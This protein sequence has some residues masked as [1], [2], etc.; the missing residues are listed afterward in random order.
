[1]NVKRLIN[2]C[3]A[4]IF[5][6][7]VVLAILYLTLVPRPLPELDIPLFPGADKVVHAIMMMGMMWCIG[8]DLM[9]HKSLSAPVAPKA[10]LAIALL[11]TV[12]LGGAIEIIQGAMKMGRGEDIYDFLADVIGAVIGFIVI[13]IVWEPL[14]RW[15]Q[16]E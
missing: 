2:R 16:D 15:L 14:V 5:S 6:I 8:L 7:I 10:R 4:W 11:C 3:P 12:A 1:M 9:R 13:V